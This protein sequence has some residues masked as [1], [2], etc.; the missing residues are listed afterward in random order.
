R[1]GLL[2]TPFIDVCATYRRF[3][4][5]FREGLSYFGGDFQ[6][7]ASQMNGGGVKAYRPDGALAWEWRYRYPIV[8]S[9]LSTAGDILF[10]GTPDGL[11]L[12]LD[13]RNGTQLWQFR[14]GSGIHS[15]PV[16]Y[17]VNGRQFVAVPTGWGGWIKGFAPNM[18]GQERGS[19]VFVF[20]LPDGGGGR[21]SP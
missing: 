16:T 2:Y 7:D 19:A 17:S 14:T 20:A 4:T 12:A 18:I 15:N 8:A 11:F 13:A 1:T 21:P 6:V 5:P 10:V 9:L 3:E